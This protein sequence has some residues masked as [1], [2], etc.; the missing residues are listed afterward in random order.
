MCFLLI[1]TYH[2][3]FVVLF[4]GRNTQMENVDPPLPRW[5]EFEP[6][7]R[8]TF[9]VLLAV[10]IIKAYS[11]PGS[12]FPS[13]LHPTAF[14]LV[15]CSFLVYGLASGISAVFRGGIYVIACWVMAISA[16]L[17]LGSMTYLVYV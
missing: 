14:N 15:V 2:L 1:L 6:T 10:L 13:V 8:L 5:T 12:G 17:I 3:L 7:F 9:G 16:C 4:F 11:Q